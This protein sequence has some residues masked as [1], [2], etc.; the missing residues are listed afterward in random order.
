VILRD[1]PDQTSSATGEQPSARHTLPSFDTFV[2]A[3]VVSQTHDINKFS[4]A[5]HYQANGALTDPSVAS[6]VLVALLRSL[7]DILVDADIHHLDLVDATAQRPA[8]PG[9]RLDD[10]TAVVS[11]KLKDSVFKFAISVFDD[12][13]VITR[14][15]SSFNDFY[16][17]YLRLMPNAAQLEATVRQAA[18][19]SYGK[20]IEVTM[21]QFE[22]KF[23]FSDFSK[24]RWSLTR[25]PRNVDVLSKI[26]PTVPNRGGRT[27]LSEQDF[28]R[29]DLT[30]SRLEQFETP[31]GAKSRNCWYALEAPSNERGRFLIFTAQLRNVSAETLDQSPPA[32][33]RGA[34]PFD[35]DF[36]DDYLLAL[37]DFLPVRALDGFMGRLLED[38]EFGT[39]RQ[40]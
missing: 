7:A 26:L 18:A 28:L 19:R 25:L 22:F 37:T 12:R 1:D 3:G 21:T 27:E 34:I 31:N 35:P 8:E 24:D 23:V 40:L 32:A 15:G 20:P 33:R 29:V 38:W 2:D 39:Q 11:V 36:T 4:F 6:A 13:F 16:E 5:V 14:E 30:F 9:A 17:W 10:T